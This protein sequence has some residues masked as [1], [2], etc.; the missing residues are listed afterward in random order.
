MKI[1]ALF[2]L[3]ITFVFAK[4]NNLLEFSIDVLKQGF[5]AMNNYCRGKSLGFCS[6]ESIKFAK[7]YLQSQIDQ[8]EKEQERKLYDARKNEEIRQLNRKKNQI[9]YYKL[10]QRQHFIDR[11]F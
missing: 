2:F 3:L 9:M 8:K 1:L 10:K 4:D 5:E 11:H 7:A 6:S